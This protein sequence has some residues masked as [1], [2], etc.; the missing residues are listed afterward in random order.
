LGVG[1]G[2]NAA[3]EHFVGGRDDTRDH[4]AWGEGDLFVFEEVVGDGLVEDETA[5]W[6]EGD[7]FRRPEF[8]GVERVEGKVGVAGLDGEELVVDSPGG[9]FAGLDVGDEVGGGEG[10]RHF[11]GV[12][13]K[14]T[15]HTLFAL[16]VIADIELT[17]S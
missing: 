8:G 3:L 17:T 5:K 13:V 10:E 9:E 4:T 1:V 7:F 2:E 12:F 15:T 14:E 11:Y 16:E 6:A